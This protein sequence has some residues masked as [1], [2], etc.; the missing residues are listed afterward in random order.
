MLLLAIF[1]TMKKRNNL[2]RMLIQYHRKGT[3][4]TF[5]YF[6]YHQLFVLCYEYNICQIQNT[7]LY[8]ISKFDLIKS[9]HSKIIALIRC[10]DHIVIL[11]S[12]NFVTQ[13]YNN[14]IFLSNY[15]KFQHFNNL[16][17]VSLVWFWVAKLCGSDCLLPTFTSFLWLE[18]KI[19]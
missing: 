14:T 2:A 17:N 18:M 15:A 16:D 10:I 12:N 1:C 4:V 5:W 13:L 3:I 6:W 11:T 19:C 7:I 9:L 8:L